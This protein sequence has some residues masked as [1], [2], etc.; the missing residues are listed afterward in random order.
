MRLVAAVV[1][2]IKGIAASGHDLLAFDSIIDDTKKYLQYLKTNKA[3][4]D[5]SFNA[6]FSDTTKEKLIFDIEL[7]SYFAIKKI[8]F[9]L[10]AGPGA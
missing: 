7:I 8:N 6:R 9:S 1:S 4:L 2:E 10:A 5:Y 3:I